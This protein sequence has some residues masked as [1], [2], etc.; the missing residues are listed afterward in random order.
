[1]AEIARS[2]GRSAFGRAAAFYDSARPPYPAWVFEHLAELC[3]EPP[4]SGFE[5]GAGAGL[6]TRPLLARFPQ[7]ALAAIEPDE[8]LAGR[9]PTG[10]RLSVI[11]QPF[12]DAV[13]ERGAFDLGLAATSFHWVDQAVGLTKAAALLRSGGLW[14][15][16]ANT[17]GDSTRADAFHDATTGLLGPPAMT[18]SGSDALPY[19]L[20]A[21]AR[22][23]DLHA[24]GAFTDL[25][26][27]RRNW[28][29]VIDAAQVR[30]LY[31]TYSNITTRPQ[32]ERERL[33]DGLAE[34]AERQF[35]GRV[36]RNMVTS[37][38]AARRL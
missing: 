2:A 32:A 34:V 15:T 1:M 16:I 12:E 9:L 8:R 7:M 18:P 10:G 19:A 24:T 27:E 6:A 37:L 14:A 20:D 25:V 5:V 31:A 17:F 30:A 13:L 23:A 29:L 35:A 36:E 28:T 3:Q 4:R 11:T 21:D 38:V 33:L 26:F 22:H